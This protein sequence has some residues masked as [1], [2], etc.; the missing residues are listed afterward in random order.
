MNRIVLSVLTISLTAHNALAEVRTWTSVSGAQMEAEFVERVIDDVVLQ[1]AEGEKIEIRMNQ[2]SPED[3]KYVANLN[4]KP[5]AATTASGEKNDA[6]TALFGSRLTN[7]D[8]KAVDTA[9][10]S[11]KKIGIYFSAQWCPPCRAF[12]PGLVDAYNQMQADG[13]PFEIVFVSSDRTEADMYKYMREYKMPWKALRFDS[14]EK[15][16]LSKKFNIRG[17]P[18]LIIVD[19]DGRTISGSGRADIAAHGAKAFD[20]W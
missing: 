8:K 12:T 3:Q 10:L 17:I 18:A 4:R 5:D 16:A 11:G 19:S 1:N 20:K 13:K 2:L 14:K 15:E 9:E 6:L 7:A